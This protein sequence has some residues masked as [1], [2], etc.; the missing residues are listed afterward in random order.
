GSAVPEEQVWRDVGLL[1]A[2]GGS[3]WR[4]GHSS[5]GPQFLAAGDAFGVMTI[6]PSGDG[7]NGFAVICAGTGSTRAAG[8]NANADDV[9][10]KRETHRD[11]IVHDRNNP[12][13]LAWEADNGSTDTSFAQ[14]IKA[15]SRVWEPVNTR[16]QADRTPNPANGDILGCSGDGCDVGVKQQFPN[17]PSFGAEYWG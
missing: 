16:A 14:G 12:S 8:C 7:E 9:T 10:L 1:A 11:M 3:L 6:Q 2:A 4:P 15:L 5:Q 17:S 13:V